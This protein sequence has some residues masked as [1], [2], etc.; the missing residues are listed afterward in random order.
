MADI[1]TLPK[2]AE[3]LAS[4]GRL[5]IA[6]EMLNYVLRLTIKT[7][8]DEKLTASRDATKKK[9]AKWLRKR[10]AESAVDRGMDAAVLRKL[11]QLLLQAEN[12]ADKR[13]RIVHDITYHTK[14]GELVLQEDNDPPRRYPSPADID[15]ITS[16]LQSVAAELNV[17]RKDGGFLG[18][19]IHHADTSEDSVTASLGLI[20][21]I[22]PH[23]GSA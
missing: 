23:E 20:L 16:E 11:D 18:L 5:V 6:N 17:A 22:D 1:L 13:N 4:V 14:S 15:L 8:R 2:D 21:T 10:V 9:T 7:L 19:V 12:A 3:L